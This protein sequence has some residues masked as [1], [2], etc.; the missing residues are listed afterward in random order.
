M[1]WT[2]LSQTI[3]VCLTLSETAQL[4]CSEYFGYVSNRRRFVWDLQ[5]PCSIRGDATSGMSNLSSSTSMI[6]DPMV[7]ICVCAL[8][9]IDP[10]VWCVAWWEEKGAGDQ[11]IRYK[12]KTNK[13]VKQL[14]SQDRY[15]DLLKSCIWNILS[16]ASVYVCAWSLSRVWLFA[17]L[18]TAALQAPL[19][20]GIL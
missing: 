14:T 17:A 18:C 8:E 4:S 12:N 16:L 1:F 5:S 20:M 6:I 10:S 13:V 9:H 3:A 7:W 2:Q 19:S 11:V 15:E